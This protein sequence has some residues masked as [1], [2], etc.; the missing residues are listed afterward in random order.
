M[1]LDDRAAE[2]IF[3]IRDRDGKFIGA[4]MQ[5]SPARAFASC[6]HQCEN[7]GKCNYE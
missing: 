6:A 2:F 4:L 3:L 5:C 7:P 1:H